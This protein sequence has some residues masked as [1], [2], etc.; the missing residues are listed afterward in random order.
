[1]S[2]TDL[3]PQRQ[4]AKVYCLYRK[5]ERPPLRIKMALYVLFLYMIF[6]VVVTFL[7]CSII[8]LLRKRLLERNVL[9]LFDILKRKKT[10]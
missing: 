7:C 9:K 6:A 10:N 5:L 3:D 4:E 2:K 1:M 8:D